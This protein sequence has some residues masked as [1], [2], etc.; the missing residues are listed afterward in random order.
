[1]VQKESNRIM[2][3][4]DL[5][6]ALVTMF[7]APVVFILL[8]AINI[9]HKALTAHAAVPTQTIPADCEQAQILKDDL[10]GTYAICIQRVEEWPHDKLQITVLRPSGDTP[11]GWKSDGFTF[12]PLAK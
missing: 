10:G 4:N 9:Q 1:M 11:S 7:G 8:L 5:M 6:I 2:G 3:L 12:Y